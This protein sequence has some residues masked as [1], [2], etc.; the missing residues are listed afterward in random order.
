VLIRLP[1]ENKFASNIL[2][3]NYDTNA[4]QEYKR[5]MPPCINDGKFDVLKKP[6]KAKAQVSID[7]QNVDD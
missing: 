1:L 2:G 3:E 7:I 4:I 6:T 5:L